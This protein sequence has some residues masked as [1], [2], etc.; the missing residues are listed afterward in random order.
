MAESTWQLSGDYFETCNCDF[1][2]PCAPSNLAAPPTLGDCKAVMVFHI[3]EGR[4][5]DTPLDD[6]TFVVVIYT[7]GAMIEGNWTVGLIVD[8]RASAE[9]EEAI[10][11]IVSG[12]EGGPLAITSRL[13]TNFAGV[14]RKPIHFEKNGMT[15]S[16]SIPGMVDQ[17]VEGM[18]SR[19]KPGEPLFLDNLGH[20]ANSRLALAK[21][22]HSHLHAFGLDWDDTSGQNN[23]HFAPFYWKGA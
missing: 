18:P 2:C 16:V 5:G 14:E 10:T 1:L 11:A 22:T 3:N 12:K 21:A 7:P 4:H 13:V 6:L 23:G 9:Q 8:E 15:C 19:S 20:P 17:A